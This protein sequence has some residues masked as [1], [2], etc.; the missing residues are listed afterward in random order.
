MTLLIEVI[1]ASMTIPVQLIG[2][3]DHRGRNINTM[4]LLKM[5]RQRLRDST[6][7]TTE[8]ECFLILQGDAQCCHSVE[9]RSN[10]SSAGFE[11][12]S[13]APPAASFSGVC[14]DRPER[15]FFPKLLP[16]FLDLRLQPRGSLSSGVFRAN[17]LID[18][19]R[20]L[21]GSLPRK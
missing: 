16:G 8:V 6:R 18:G 4:Y 3:G 1:D 10:V 13:L 12:F 11:E 21:S 2:P 5:L 9:E 19:Q 20:L 15:I 17:L 14:H 7:S